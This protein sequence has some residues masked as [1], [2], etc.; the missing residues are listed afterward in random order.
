MALAAEDAEAYGMV[1]T[2]SR[3]P[4]TDP[5]RRAD[6]PEAISASIQ[7]PMTT[8]AA[9]VD[10][11][12]LLDE[13][14]TITNRHL[15]SDLAIAAV[16][17]DAAARSSRWNVLVNAANLTDPEQRMDK[18]RQMNELL[19]DSRRLMEKVETACEA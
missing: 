8:I 1:N 6:L 5:R 7:V 3:L 9:C 10:I 2:L 17:A 16:L 18:A 14:S 13:L 11:L 12:R 15:R 19:A 4:D